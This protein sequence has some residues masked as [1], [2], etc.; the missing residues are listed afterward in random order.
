MGGSQLQC[1]PAVQRS[2]RPR[3]AVPN[4]E[5]ERR[6]LGEGVNDKLAEIEPLVRGGA[7]VIEA[8]KPSGF[9]SGIYL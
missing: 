4:G 6:V 2:H 1:L 8:S 7:K 9:V 5:R 3:P